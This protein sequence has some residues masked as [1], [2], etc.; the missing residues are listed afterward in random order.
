MG[1][2]SARTIKVSTL[3]IPAV[4]LDLYRL[5]SRNIRYRREGT[6][7]GGSTENL[8]I[9]E[10]EMDAEDI[11]VSVMLEYWVRYCNTRCNITKLGAIL[12]Y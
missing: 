9:Q 1:A 5:C 12:Q 10:V 7:L 8:E 6:H 3:T 4:Y 2:L 11:P